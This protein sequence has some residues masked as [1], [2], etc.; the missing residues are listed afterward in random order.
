MRKGITG[1]LVLALITIG[2]TGVAVARATHNSTPVVDAAGEVPDDADAA[3]VVGHIDTGFAKCLPKRTVKVFF[4]YIGES[5]FRLVDVATS[6]KHGSFSGIG[7]I[8]HN[9]NEAVV[10]KVKLL[11]KDLGSEGKCSGGVG[12][13]DD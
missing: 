12:T 1:A 6:S 11:A 3:Y 9:G 13:L 8:T 2:A 5:K 10:I 7:P 4:G